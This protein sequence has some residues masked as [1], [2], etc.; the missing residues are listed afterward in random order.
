MSAKN[1]FDVIR[2]QMASAY[3]KDAAVLKAHQA[4]QPPYNSKKLSQEEESLL[5][6]FPERAFPNL[7]IPRE[8]ARIQLKDQMGAA[9][10]AA[11]IRR[12]AGG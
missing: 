8:Q 9:E 5:Y 11:F 4:K 12:N 10:Y 6:Q 2:T 3:Q 7:P 1:E